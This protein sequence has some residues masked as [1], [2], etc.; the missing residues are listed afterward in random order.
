[1]IVSSLDQNHVGDVI[2]TRSGADSVV[3]TSTAT[4]QG[5]NETKKA[6]SNS[7]PS[8][9]QRWLSIPLGWFWGSE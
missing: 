4:E 8:F 7:E 1:M 9:W 3:T 2:E 5:N 6:D